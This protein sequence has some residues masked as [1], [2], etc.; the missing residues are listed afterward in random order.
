LGEIWGN[1]VI[2]SP[3]DGVGETSGGEELLNLARTQGELG[4]A[5]FATTS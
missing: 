2:V 1:D 5:G 4:A 3:G